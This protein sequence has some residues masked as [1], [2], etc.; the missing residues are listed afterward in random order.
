[1]SIRYTTKARRG[2][3]AAAIAACLALAVGGC[4]GDEKPKKE[5]SGTT[6]AAS[7]SSGS[8]KG[9]QSDESQETLAVL[10]GQSGLELTLNSAKRDVGGFLTVNGQL[11][12]TSDRAVF[13]PP[14]LSGNETEI[15][16]HGTSL[17]GA[18]LVDPVGKKR[19]YVLRDTEGRP[20]ATS[21]LSSLQAD[22]SEEVFV[23]F[24]APPA[25]TAEVSFSLPTFGPA[26]IKLTK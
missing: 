15:V 23:Q 13:L 16:K 11:K 18:T 5:A 26:T 20:L 22:A 10:K 19:Y 9:K 1:M 25:S 8:D 7:E 4:G 2:M 21:G 6:P 24:P 12:N 14:Q 3:A 17:G